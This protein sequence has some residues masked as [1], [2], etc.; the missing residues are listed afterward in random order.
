MVF[1]DEMPAA[2]A[3]MFVKILSGSA[4]LS[5]RNSAPPHSG[6]TGFEVKR[7]MQTES[8]ETKTRLVSVIVNLSVISKFNSCNLLS[9]LHVYHQA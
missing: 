3:S 9:S 7:V 4:I 5:S 1:N 2:P 8:E 6:Q